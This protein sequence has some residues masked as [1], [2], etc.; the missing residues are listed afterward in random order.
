MKA[1]E[2]EPHPC[3]P[4]H[5]PCN[6]VPT[7]LLAGLRAQLLARA[8]YMVC[9]LL[10]SSAKHLHRLQPCATRINTMGVASSFI[11]F[12]FCWMTPCREWTFVPKAAV[13]DSSMS[14]SFFKDWKERTKTQDAEH[15]NVIA[16][17]VLID[18]G[19][20]SD[21]QIPVNCSMIHRWDHNCVQS[22]V[23]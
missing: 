17:R 12:R 1:L 2:Y 23:E 5:A 14:A 15:S 4:K 21:K 9:T 11:L 8:W 20:Q 6:T 13:H 3:W 16:G 22:S 19:G 10:V 7:I 18:R